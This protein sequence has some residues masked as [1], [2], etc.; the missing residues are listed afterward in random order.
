MCQ[1]QEL[2]PKDN[3]ITWRNVFF[4]SARGGNFSALIFLYCYGLTFSI[5]VKS[6]ARIRFNIF[7]PNFTLKPTETSENLWF[8]VL[9]QIKREHWDKMGLKY[10]RST[11]FGN[12]QIKARFSLKKWVTVTSD[13]RSQEP[14]GFIR[15]AK[16]V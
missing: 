8:Y 1:G 10:K 11:R 7:F 5:S 14:T 4:L 13:Q 16:I 6:G 2:P 12:K 15:V 9:R 3:A